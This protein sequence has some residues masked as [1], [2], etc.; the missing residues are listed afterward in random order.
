MES[1]VP[2]GRVGRRRGGRRVNHFLGDSPGSGDPLRSSDVRRRNEKLVLRLIRETGDRGLSQS[3]AVG[4]TGLRAPTMLRIFSSLEESG[5]IEPLPP[6]ASE[7]EGKERKGRPPVS[8]AAKADAYYTLGVEFWVDRVSLGLF[9]FRGKHLSSSILSLRGGEDAETV[10]EVIAEGVRAAVA[11]PG[12]AGESILGLG[13]G[14]PGQVD[15][16][17]RRITFY[18]R[19]PGMRDYPMA[20]I[21]E[22]KLGIPVHLHNNCA[23][24][25]LSEYRY[26]S[27][28]KTDSL[29]MFLLRSGVNGAFIDHG[30]IHLTSDGTTL[31]SGHIPID[32][33][34]KPCVC[35]ARGCLEPYL[36][37]LA[38]EDLAAGRYLFEGL[39][40]AL[41]A[42][43]PKARE[44]L[45]E[46]AGYLASAV[47]S[48]R[49]LLNPRAFLFVTASAPVS[50]AL[51]ALVPESLAEFPSGFDEPPAAFIGNVYNPGLVQRGA[52]DLV[53]DVFL[54]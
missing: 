22:R 30:R 23:V 9:D 41:A 31:E 37:D 25:A 52:A 29:F 27:V 40:S 17:S 33:R 2:E 50:D 36:A 14:A 49:R 28:G 4:S 20:E 51:A 3:E 46:A 21:L 35:G 34:G 54:G 42:G 16:R 11:A 5:Y 39:G 15:V 53:L 7:E 10:T 18:S 48:V 47:R 12:L 44:I 26:G 19:I 1:R 8:F 6:A 45:R 13:L 38:K 32:Y 24:I 43:D